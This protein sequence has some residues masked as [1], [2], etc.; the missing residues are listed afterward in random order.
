LDFEAV[1]VT[2][3]TSSP[4]PSLIDPLNVL[5][6]IGR[7]ARRTASRAFCA[8]ALAMLVSARVQQPAYRAAPTGTAI[9]S[10]EFKRAASS[11]SLLLRGGS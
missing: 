2:L 4:V 10:S 1:S 9:C 7:I 3:R 6:M 5:K 11:F 8:L